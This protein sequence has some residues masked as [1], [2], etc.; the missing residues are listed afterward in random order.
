MCT[1]NTSSSPLRLPSQPKPRIQEIAPWQQQAVRKRSG[2]TIVEPLIVSVVVVLA[3]AGSAALIV[4]ANR[5]FVVSQQRIEMNRQIDSN[6]QAIKDL[7]RKYTCCAGTCSTSPPLAANT[8]TGTGGAITKSCVTTDWRSRLYY[9]PA[10]DD[11]NTTA[12]FAGT[13]PLTP[14]EL[15]AVDQICQTANNTAF[16]T[17]FQ[18]A[19]NATAIPT[20]ANWSRA[21]TIQTEKTLRITY[22]DTI[23]NVA[24]R[25]EYVQPIM[26]SYCSASN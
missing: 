16:M 17:P 12:N 13:N 4:I 14:S 7:A 22:T 6:L 10:R 20:G 19:V 25:T 1:V 5:R 9:S 26:A 8:Q 24:L 2:F 23:N 11:P 18:T 3:M 21:T 15:N